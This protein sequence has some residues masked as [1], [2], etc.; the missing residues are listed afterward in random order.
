MTIRTRLLAALLLIGGLTAA[1]ASWLAAG[2]WADVQGARR[3]DA[4]AATLAHIA[5]A[6][7]AVV[8]EAARLTDTAIAAPGAA[9]QAVQEGLQAAAAAS[10]RAVQG[11][12][13]AAAKADAALEALRGPLLEAA[14]LP[15]DE[16][17]RAAADGLAQALA[18]TLGQLRQTAATLSREAAAGAPAAAAALGMAEESQTLFE[19]MSDRSMTLS[20]G[21][22]GGALGYDKAVAATALGG[23]VAEAWSRLQAAATEAGLN[24]PVLAEAATTLAEGLMQ[25]GERSFAELVAAARDGLPAPMTYAAFRDWTGPTIAA[26]LAPRDLALAEARRL[27]DALAAGAQ[28]RLLIAGGAILLTALA[29]ALSTLLLVLRVARPLHVLTEAVGRIAQGELDTPL[30]GDGAARARPS[31]DE[32]AGMAE[33]LRQLRA[34]AVTARRLSAEAA[35]EQAARIQR[36][37]RLEGLLAGFEADIASGLQ[38]VAQAAQRLDGTALGVTGTAGQGAAAAMAAA[39]ASQGASGHIG[40]VAAS[41]EELASSIDAVAREVNASAEAAARATSLVRAAEA[42]VQSLAGAAEAVTPVLGLIDA[43]ARQTNLLALNATIE[44]ARA[45]D[46]GRGFAVVAGEVKALAQQTAQATEQIVAQVDAMRAGSGSAVRAMGAIA[47]AMQ[48]LD[49]IA[50]QVAAATE[51]Q[52]A[53]TRGIAGAVAHAAAQAEEASLQAG[54]TRERLDEMGT[55]FAALRQDAGQLAG[56]TTAMH[57]RT[58]AFLTA[59]RAA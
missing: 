23:R 27:S 51:Q 18:A 11:L 59:V 33:A 30:P 31:R 52:S 15:R 17:E 36:G 35:A 34:E 13:G 58:D 54:G 2:A 45:G 20:Q 32:I 14:R 55:A 57:D 16:R 40:A 25:D 24:A 29:V 53:A 49:A 42:E 56:Q 5:A 19:L 1:L 47:N 46:A 50:G 48:E 44:A 43:I 38:A 12:P 22:A 4:A 21:I 8:E 10:R 39:G 9:E 28:R 6:R 3:V 37:Q 26:A 7:Q 41:A